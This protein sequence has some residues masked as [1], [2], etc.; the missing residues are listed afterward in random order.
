MISFIRSL[1]QG[2]L[3][4]YHGF[5]LSLA[6]ASKSLL[7]TALLPFVYVSLFVPMF[8]A[9]EGLI[10]GISIFFGDG[11]LSTFV[12]MFWSTHVNLC[13]STIYA[14]KLTLYYNTLYSSMRKFQ[15]STMDK[16]K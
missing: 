11:V 6:V 12:N 1:F 4:R 7:I 3:D 13:I 15:F 5:R 10:Y 2:W 9:Q 16:L 14:F 8:M